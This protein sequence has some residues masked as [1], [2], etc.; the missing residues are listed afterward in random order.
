MFKI[1]RFVFLQLLTMDIHGDVQLVTTSATLT[2]IKIIFFMLF[3]N[4]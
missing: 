2:G 1:N 3:N 4:R